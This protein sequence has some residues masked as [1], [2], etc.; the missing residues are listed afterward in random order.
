[1]V[2]PVLSIRRRRGFYRDD[3]LDPERSDADQQLDPNRWRPSLEPDERRN[4]DRGHRYR[5]Q[6][7]K[8]HTT[9]GDYPADTRS[10]VE[11]NESV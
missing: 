7:L 10:A 11:L 3:D 4:P 1:M 8:R 5:E 6:P 9:N 2:L